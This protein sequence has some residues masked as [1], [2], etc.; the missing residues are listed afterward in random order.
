MKDFQYL[1]LCNHTFKISKKDGVE[2]EIVINNDGTSLI[3]IIVNK[4]VVL[5]IIEVRVLESRPYLKIADFEYDNDKTLQTYEDVD[6]E[7]GY[8]DDSDNFVVD[9]SQYMRFDLDGS[10][11]K[12][13]YEPTLH[14]RIRWNVRPPS[15]YVVKARILYSKN[16]EI[17]YKP[18]ECL[19][20]QGK[21]WYVDILNNDGRFEVPTGV[22]K[23]VQRVVKDI[24]TKAQSNRFDL[25]EG[26]MLHIQM[27]ESK[28]D[29][30]RLFDDIRL[31]VSD[32]EDKYLTRQ[33]DVLNE[34]RDDETLVSLRVQNI[35]RSKRNITMIFL[36]LGVT[37]KNNYEIFR[38]AI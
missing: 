7:D 33:L 15:K 1:H 25:S 13:F 6:S 2:R 20:C 24:L 35:S 29:D 31:I 5:E 38:V 4:A 37:T 3:D 27:T 16:G 8:Y 12:E 26:T 23:I 22:S 14:N 32:V 9:Y 36:E 34:L 11:P 19:R 17:T 28:G 10:L 18:D 30:E 21:G